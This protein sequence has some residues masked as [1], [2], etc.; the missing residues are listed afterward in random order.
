MI[1]PLVDEVRITSSADSTI[2]SGEGLPTYRRPP[3]LTH[4]G[5]GR[6]EVKEFNCQVRLKASYCEKTRLCKVYQS[7]HQHTHPENRRYFNAAFVVKHGINALNSVCRLALN[8]TFSLQKIVSCIQNEVVAGA[9]HPLEAMRLLEA[10][11]GNTRELSKVVRAV[12]G[13]DRPLTS[14][15]LDRLVG[16]GYARIN[17]IH[18]NV[19]CPFAVG[20]NNKVDTLGKMTRLC[21]TVTCRKMLEILRLS[22]AN[23]SRGI[24][25]DATYKTTTNGTKL[26]TI[27]CNDATMKFFP[28]SLAYLLE[29]SAEEYIWLF[30]HLRRVMQTAL[31]VNAWCP[32]FV[33][34][35]HSKA[36]TKAVTCVFPS[37]VRLTCYFHAI[38]YITKHICPSGRT[39]LVRG[40]SIDLNSTIRSDLALLSESR[41]KRMFRTLR[42]LFVSRWRDI[43]EPTLARLLNTTYFNCDSWSSNWYAGAGNSSINRTNNLLESFNRELKKNVTEYNTVPFIRAMESILDPT[44]FIANQ[45]LNARSFLQELPIDDEFYMPI[46]ELAMAYIKVCTDMLKSR[47]MSL[48]FRGMSED[49]CSF[50]CIM[51]KEVESINKFLEMDDTSIESFSE[52]RFSNW[53]EAKHLV[54]TCVRITLPKNSEHL[55]NVP[56]TGTC[57]QCLWFRKYS[58]CH[59]IIVI[60]TRLSITTW[61]KGL[62]KVSRPSR[63][64]GRTKPKAEYPGN[65]WRVRKS[66]RREPNTPDVDHIASEPM[67][68]DSNLDID[69]ILGEDARVEGMH[70]DDGIGQSLFTIGSLIIV[71]QKQKVGRKYTTTFEVLVVLGDTGSDLS[72]ELLYCNDMGQWIRWAGEEWL[73][74]FKIVEYS[75]VWRKNVQLIDGYIEGCIHEEME[76]LITSKM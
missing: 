63:A 34:A 32:S 45:A 49:S 74:Q 14:E 3:R 76:S 51:P 70:E 54:K 27:G 64:F 75:Q 6:P 38:S 5:H 61:P 9:S 17:S 62:V 15:D 58:F 67:Y 68:V 22:T 1:S 59:H 25:I 31:N 39:K 73:D 23:V 11:P 50:S 55:R 29:E 41:D 65:H 26:V 60:A 57:C 33:Q 69:E 56:S 7:L 20:C 52:G 16:L 53:D 21:I 8:P 30:E 24:Y 43:H 48:V 40:Q 42:D 46:W 47:P 37:A 71:S 10:C 4:R 36:I 2:G 12:R 13:E 44:G 18:E 66:Q 35:D 72:C 28:V 19:Y